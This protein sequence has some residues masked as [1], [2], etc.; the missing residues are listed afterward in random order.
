VGPS[1]RIVC[2]DAEASSSEQR[3]RDS[4]AATRA[5]EAAQEA[6]AGVGGAGRV[7][8][9]TSGFVVP[10]PLALMHCDT[11]QVFTK[12][13]RGDEGA[14]TRGGVLG[15]GLLLGAAT[16]AHGR[17]C[18]CRKAEILAIDGAR[19]GEGLICVRRLL[20]GVVWWPLQCS[21]C[22][23][24]RRCPA[25]TPDH[26]HPTSHHQVHPH[27]HPHH[28]PL[29]LSQMTTAGTTAWLPTTHALAFGK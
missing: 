9:V 20:P 2:R 15:L 14:R 27:A 10:P 28:A 18:G 25:Q 16:F 7:L 6:A 23:L 8:A 12:G 19:A 24:F 13:Q 1:Y 26:Q 3:P 11:L 5:W 22:P 17:A 21:S 29:P 4:S